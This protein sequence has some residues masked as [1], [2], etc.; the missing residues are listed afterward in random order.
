VRNLKGAGKK[1]IAVM[2]GVWKCGS[3]AFQSA[4]Y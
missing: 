3:I 4:F 2:E 1:K